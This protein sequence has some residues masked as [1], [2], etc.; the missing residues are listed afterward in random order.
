M[1]IAFLK[2]EPYKHLYLKDNEKK[3]E[4][5]TPGGD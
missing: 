3:I 4:I 5:A 1:T 2:R